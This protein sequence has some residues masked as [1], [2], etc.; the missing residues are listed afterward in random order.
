MKKYMPL[1][2]MTIYD[3][4]CLLIVFHRL[5]AESNDQSQIWQLIYDNF[6]YFLS[7]VLVWILCFTKMV[8]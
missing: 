3:I 2:V 7:V 6:H 1:I 5:L 8:D 4:M